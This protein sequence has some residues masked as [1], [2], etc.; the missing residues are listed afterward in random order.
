[1][2]GAPQRLSLVL[3]AEECLAHDPGPD[4]PE[5]AERVRAVHQSLEAD[6]I[7]NTT[8]RHPRQAEASE[9]Q[10][11][12]SAVHVQRMADTAGRL[13]VQLDPDTAASARSYEAALWSA[14]AALD[15]TE[16]VVT[17][18]AQ[19]AF[20]LVRPPGHHALPGAAM[21]FCLFNNVAVAAEHA[22]AELGCRRV[23]VLD[24][25]V[26]HGNGTQAA[27]WGRDDVLYVSSHRFPFYPGT[28]DVDEIGAGRGEG[29]TINL[30]LPGGASDADFLHAYEQVVAPVVDEWEP[31]LVLVSAGF[32][33]WAWDPLGGML[34]TEDGYRALYELFA[35]WAER[36]CPGRIA[37]VLEGGYNTSGVVA[38]VRSALGALTA[39][40]SGDAP[41]HPEE[42]PSRAARSMTAD[43]RRL[44]SDRWRSLR[45]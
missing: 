25:D 41:P 4:H 27:F 39:M 23:L 28:G 17:G 36:H 29:F 20:A 24:P 18:K 32:D 14:G 43:V 5:R 35:G 38:G 1:M 19:G 34:M 2:S 13:H 26:H 42:T 37:C 30:P 8:S 44:L 33:T 11:V 6:P 31:D 3:W 45:D 21:G 12:H 16:S 40:G 7:A 22:I 15:A 9:L 10:R